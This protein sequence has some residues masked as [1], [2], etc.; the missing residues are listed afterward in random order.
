ML[1]E[2]ILTIFYLILWDPRDSNPHRSNYELD[3]FTNYAKV[4]LILVPLGGIEP[5]FNDYRSFSLPLT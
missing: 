3:A 1:Q 5:P 4:P 2:R